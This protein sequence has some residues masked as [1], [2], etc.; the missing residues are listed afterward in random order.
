[1]TGA[2]TIERQNGID[3]SFAGR[4]GDRRNGFSLDIDFTAPLQGITALFGPSGC[5]KTSLLRCIAGLNR[6]PGHLSVGDE[7]WQDE[8]RGL[9]LPPHRRAVGYVFQEAS[10][11]PHLSVA[12]N[13]GL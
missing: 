6:L 11:F 10:L 5:G 2:V 8:A 7:A 9:Y 1:M 3:A 13:L 12:K 4:L